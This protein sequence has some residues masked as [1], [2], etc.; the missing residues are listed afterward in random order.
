MDFY[1]RYTYM[2]TLYF[3]PTHTQAHLA[4]RV[5]QAPLGWTV[6][7]EAEEPLVHVD[8]LGPPECLAPLD[9]VGPEG[10]KVIEGTRAGRGEP[11]PRGR[12]ARGVLLVG[13]FTKSAS[14]AL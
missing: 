3:C 12:K 7:L 8:R 14:G 5:P 6:A 11:G 4:P 2:Y 1:P 13:S 9:R 10:R